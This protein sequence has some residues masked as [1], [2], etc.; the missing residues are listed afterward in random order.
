MSKQNNR[1][2]ICCLLSIVMCLSIIVCSNNGDIYA[3]DNNLLLNGS[4]E[5]GEAPWK[6]ENWNV[7]GGACIEVNEGRGRAIHGCVCDSN[8]KTTALVLS[9]CRRK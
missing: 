7:D 8:G 1:W 4:F 5:Q 3:E 6:P 2:F 9:Q